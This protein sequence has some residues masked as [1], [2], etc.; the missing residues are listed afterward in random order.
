MRR[1]LLV[2]PIALTLASGVG[3][4]EDPISS[5]TSSEGD[6]VTGDGGGD[7][8]TATGDG[9]GEAATGDGEAA[10][11]DG[12]T[13][14]EAPPSFTSFTVNGSSM[15][16]V[17]EAAS[18][19]R[20]EAEVSDPDDDIAYIVFR[21]DGEAIS[22]Q[23]GPGTNFS[24]EWL[25]SGVELNGVYTFDAEVYDSND[26]LTL[27]QAI[28]LPIGMPASGEVETW[29][30]D[31]GEADRAH[32]IWID[33]EGESVII[34][35]QTSVMFQAQARTDRVVGPP[36]QDKNEAGSL[37][38]N[39]IARR[40]GGGFFVAGGI[41]V[42][43]DSTDTTLL[44]YDDDGTLLDVFNA[45]V[46]SQIGE[47]ND[48]A[49]DMGLTPGGVILLGFYRPSG[50]PNA[51]QWSSY[52]RRYTNNFDVEYTRFPSETLAGNPTG[53]DLSAISDGSFAMA[54]GRFNEQLPVPWFG[55]FDSAGELLSEVVVDDVDSGLFNSVHLG[56][57]GIITVG[58]QV[59]QGLINP[60]WVRRYDSS[61]EL[62]LDIRI[63]GSDIGI[64]TAVDVD[65][66]G[67]IVVVSTERCT[68]DD[69]TYRNCELVV[70]KYDADG[71]QM[72]EER[73]DSGFLGP[74]LL[75]PGLN[76]SVEI[77]RYGYIYVTAVTDSVDG[78]DWWARK[79]HP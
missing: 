79:L 50:G 55:R 31:S 1:D 40:G 41:N 14:N 59:S 72:W 15:P 56:E 3:C 47:D 6:D 46:T 69:I 10:T 29:T 66:W 13:A 16:G 38:G 61:G 36:W 7:G 28:E 24:F 33:D 37:S 70:H 44:H 5:S 32:A 51:G 52:L 22:S 42:G 60:S 78:G 68:L 67:E 65:P 20:L 17:V 19:V 8:E 34:T 12:D 30:H 74:E 48:F 64:V 4:F 11:G 54:G 35:G 18:A 73:Y 57:D 23:D 58:G 39:A 75:L 9:D 27:S 71:D 45:N 53:F 62:L 49:V 76:A 21:R 26:N 43:L 63:P 2:A 25:V 77:D